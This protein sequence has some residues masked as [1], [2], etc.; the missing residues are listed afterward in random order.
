MEKVLEPYLSSVP[1]DDVKYLR[2]ASAYCLP[3]MHWYSKDLTMSIPQSMSPTP[4]SSPDSHAFF[5]LLL[6][7]PSGERI[8]LRQQP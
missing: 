7:I 1:G 2:R 3:G 5:R 8:P 6:F 4:R